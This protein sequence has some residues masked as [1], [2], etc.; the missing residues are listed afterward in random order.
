MR[1]DRRAIS[2]ASLQIDLPLL[3]LLRLQVCLVPLHHG[4]VVLATLLYL[5]SEVRVLV[6]DSYLLL[7]A[8]LFVVQLAKAVFEHLSL[9]CT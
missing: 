1:L 3:V 6:S 9:Y 8:L 7:Q 2:T 4:S 5:I